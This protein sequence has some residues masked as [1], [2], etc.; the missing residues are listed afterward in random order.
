MTKKKKEAVCAEVLTK[1]NSI[2]EEKILEEI[3]NIIFEPLPEDPLN[4]KLDMPLLTDDLWEKHKGELI[5]EKIGDLSVL[6][7][8]EFFVDHLTNIIRK[9]PEI[10]MDPEKLLWKL[11]RQDVY[12]NFFVSEKLEKLDPKDAEKMAEQLYQDF[13]KLI[14]QIQI[15]KSEGLKI[16]EENVGIINF[17]TGDFEIVAEKLGESE[18]SEKI[19]KGTTYVKELTKEIERE[20]ISP[21]NKYKDHYG[22]FKRFISNHKEMELKEAIEM[23]EIITT[24]F[25]K[26]YR[27]LENQENLKKFID[28][29]QRELIKA[30]QDIDAR[31]QSE[32]NTLSEKL[33]GAGKILKNLGKT[34]VAKPKIAYECPDCGAEVQKGAPKCKCGLVLDWTISNGEKYDINMIQ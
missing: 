16:S 19:S 27:E 9:K 14:N 5:E 34:K 13:N 8:P 3:D 10:T 15:R 11:K 33:Q 17:L 21:E 22:N 1:T 20:I 4:P 12:L 6:I 23:A 29:E 31:G 30:V 2:K 28:E 24:E 26:L 7:N 18:I 25:S 32:V